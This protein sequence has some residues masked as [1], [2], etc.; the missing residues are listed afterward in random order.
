MTDMLPN[1]KGFDTPESL[2]NYWRA[3][4]SEVE[5]DRA[6]LRAQL[7]SE[8]KRNGAAETTGPDN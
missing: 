5:R 6:A 2:T 8:P 1:P 3:Y 7:H 4:A